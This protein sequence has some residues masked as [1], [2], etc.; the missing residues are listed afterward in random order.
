MKRYAVF[1]YGFNPNLP[2]CF[3]SA[4]GIEEAWVL[5]REALNGRTIV[6]SVVEAMSF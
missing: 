1:G 6:T 3:V 2:T 4:T 5:A